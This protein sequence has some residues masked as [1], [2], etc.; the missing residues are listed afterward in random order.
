MAGIAKS[1]AKAGAKGLRKGIKRVNPAKLAGAAKKSVKRG[2]KRVGGKAKKFSKVKS[3]GKK[4]V[5][6]AKKNKK[7]TALGVGAAAIGITTGVLAAEKAAEMRE[8]CKEKLCPSKTKEECNKICA[9]DFKNAKLCLE[10]CEK[11]FTQEGFNCNKEFC[12]TITVADGVESVAKDAVAG[13]TNAVSDAMGSV[14][15]TM[16]CGGDKVKCNQTITYAKYAAI[17]L[18]CLYILSFFM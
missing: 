2:L 3:L 14:F 12:D 16:C 18:L 1:L 6:V 4:A 10:T 7:L 9:E 17:I 11:K 15:C 5:G 8:K 13:V